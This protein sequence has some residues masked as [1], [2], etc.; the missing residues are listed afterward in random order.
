MNYLIVGN[1]FDLEHG[2]KTRYQQFMGWMG[3][4]VELYNSL[5]EEERWN[6]NLETFFD[7][8]CAIDLFPKVRRT[9][10]NLQKEIWHNMDDNFWIEYFFLSYRHLKDGW[11]GFEG[12]LKIVI[13]HI[14]SKMRA[15]EGEFLNIPI[16]KMEIKDFPDNIR[17]LPFFISNLHRVIDGKT[18][19]REFIEI[20]EDD[21]KRLIRLFE[22][23]LTNYAHRSRK[24]KL[25]M[26]NLIDKGIKRV[27]S[28][29]YT[30]TYYKWYDKSAK[31]CYIHGKADKSH[32]PKDDSLVLGINDYLDDSRAD[33]EIEMIAFK[34]YYQRL[35][36][37]SDSDYIYWIEEIEEKNNS[38]VFNGKETDYLYIIGH[39]LDIA[40]ADVLRGFLLK[41]NVY[42]T[43]YYRNEE[44][45]AK[46]IAN[47]VRVIGK[48][49][50]IKRTAG[51]RQT[52]FF[53]DQ[54]TLNK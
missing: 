54:K 40:D 50:L 44:D 21:L 24:K 18:T 31:V 6:E 10:K 30:D 41:D 27:I 38:N 23:Y 45:Y 39:S 22:I 51:K 42:T 35:K 1:G 48:R 12:E 20:L 25:M 37:K 43:I 19:Y 29:N 2:Y 34:K 49:E 4:E 15:L 17:K 36:K 47:L 8:S 13:E 32:K 28:F 9:T 53:V 33:S 11:T 46:K 16:N 3:R 26:S 7:S 14:D 5:S 52:I